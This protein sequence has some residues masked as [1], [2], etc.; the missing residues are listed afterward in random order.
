MFLLQKKRVYECANDDK[1]KKPVDVPWYVYD[2]HLPE[3]CKD[4]FNYEDKQREK[5]QLPGHQ[6]NAFVPYGSVEKFDEEY[7]CNYYQAEI[8]KR[9]C[10]CQA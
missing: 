7:Y 6:I 4:F 2:L 8:V 5:Q 3:N 1:F 9:R 10:L